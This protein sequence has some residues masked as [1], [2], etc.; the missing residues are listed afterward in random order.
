MIS[1]SS[2]SSDADDHDSLGADQEQVFEVQASTHEAGS[3]SAMPQHQG[4]PFT[5]GSI[6][7]QA[8]DLVEG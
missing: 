3:S 7:P 5:T 2:F 4:S 1:A 6:Y 8:Q